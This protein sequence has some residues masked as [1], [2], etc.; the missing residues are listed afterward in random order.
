MFENYL[1]YNYLIYNYL[2]NFNIYR[3][4][5]NVRS[6][7]AFMYIRPLAIVDIVA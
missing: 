1:C 7:F 4:V 2:T 6:I 3:T 5:K